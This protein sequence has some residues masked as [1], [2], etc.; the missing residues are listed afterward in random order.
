MK[1][2]FATWCDPAKF[3][4]FYH[5]SLITRRSDVKPS[6]N[7]VTVAIRDVEPGAIM[8]PSRF[9]QGTKPALRAA[10]ELCQVGVDYWNETENAVDEQVPLVDEAA[11]EVRSDTGELYRSWEKKFGLVD[12]EMTKAV[13]G[14]LSRQGKIAMTDM[15]VECEN[16]YAVIA[17]SSL[18]NGQGIRE[19]DSMLLTAIGNAKNTDMKVEQAPVARQNGS[20]LEPWQELIEFGKPPILAE[21]VEAT[22]RL[23]TDRTNLVVWSVDAG[24][25]YAGKVPVKY[26]DGRAV[27]T[28]GKQFE[29]VHYLV[30]AE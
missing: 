21:V 13:Y 15:E 14:R 3:G 16:E 1:A 18:N 17:L 28:I 24:G 25:C 27:F 10:A 2:P 19:S 5:A 8:R 4:L 12:T 29:T 20:A 23:K 30:Q 22:I 11:G 26:E 7:K 9:E 6:Q